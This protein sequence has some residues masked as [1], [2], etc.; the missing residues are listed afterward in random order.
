MLSPGTNARRWCFRGATAALVVALSVFTVLLYVSLVTQ[1]TWYYLMQ[2]HQLPALRH[3]TLLD[4]GDCLIGNS[5][6]VDVLIILIDLPCDAGLTIMFLIPVYSAKFEGSRRHSQA[7]PRTP[8][9]EL[10]FSQRSP[11]S[12]IIQSFFQNGGYISSWIY[13]L[14]VCGNLRL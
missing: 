7:A 5:T 10:V 3:R 13:H 12:P 6:L 4:T 9:L 8:A 2:L 14:M 1:S 11:V